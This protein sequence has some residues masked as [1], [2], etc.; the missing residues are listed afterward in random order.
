[1]A[2]THLIFLVHGMGDFAAGWSKST[3]KTLQDQY[4]TYK[5][6]KF[7]PFGQRFELVEI[8]YNDEFEALRKKWR[9]MNKALGDALKTFGGGEIGKTDEDLEVVQKLNGAAGVTDKNSFL[10]THVVDALLYYAARQTAATVRES[11]RKQIFTALKKQVDGGGV[12]RWSVVAHSLGTAVVHDALHEAFSDEPTEFGEK[13]AGIAP[14]TCIAMIANVSRLLEWDIDVYLSRTRPGNPDDPDAACRSFINAH[15]TF[16]PFTQPKAFRPAAQWP[17]V[18]TRALGLYHDIETREI[19]AAEKVHDLDH[20]LRNP[21]VHGP[22]FNCLLGLKVL[23][24]NTISDAHAQY[25]T[26]TPL[27]SFGTFVNALKEF[28]LGEEDSWAKVFTT[29]AEFRALLP[30]GIS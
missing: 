17:S 11:V 23:D 28:Q 2:N 30:K 16:D 21:A 27:G 18:A 6:L 25:V 29:W 19:E 1:V 9:D 13:L 10:N 24:D 12:I 15:N 4:A 26:H 8:L 7:I 5:Q 20:Y 14:A 3:Q 22:L